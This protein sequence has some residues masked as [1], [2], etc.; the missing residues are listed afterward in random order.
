[1]HINTLRPPTPTLF[2][3]TTL[4]RSNSITCRKHYKKYNAYGHKYY[5]FSIKRSFYYL[6][7]FQYFCKEWNSDNRYNRQKQYIRPMGIF[8][9][10]STNRWSDTF[11]HSYNGPNNTKC[12]TPIF[13]WNIARNNHHHKCWKCSCANS[14]N[15]P[16]QNKYGK[17]KMSNKPDN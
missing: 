15:K 5:S 9:N 10:H 6:F 2:P 7:L 12:F 4:F 14:L 8:G 16:S 17:E 13:F 11:S 1:Q 3:Y